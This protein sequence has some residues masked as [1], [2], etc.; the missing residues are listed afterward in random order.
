MGGK[1]TQQ[2]LMAQRRREVV[3]LDRVAA[4]VGEDRTSDL[5]FG[6]FGDDGQ[7]QRVRHRDGGTDD[8]RV[9]LVGGDVGDE[10]A[11]ELQFVGGQAVQVGERRITGPVVVDGDPH[12]E[13]GELAEHVARL[14]DVGHDLG[15]CDLERERARRKSVGPEM[16]GD[17]ADEGTIREV[18]PGDVDRQADVE[19]I[20]P[21][22]G[23][24]VTGFGEHEVG[25]LADEAH[26]LRDRDELVGWNLAVHG[27]EPARQR[28]DTDHLSGDQ[29]GDRLVHHAQLLAAGEGLRQVASE[30]ELAL[31]ALIVLGQV[32]LDARALVFRVVHRDVCPLKEGCDVVSVVGRER[33]SRRSC[34]REGD[35]IYVHRL[36]DRPEQIAHDAQG[37]FGPGDVRHDEREF[38]ASEPGNR[39]SATAR[40]DEAF[41]DLAQQPIAG[42]VAK[43]VIDFLETVEVEQGDCRP[44]RLCERVRRAI[45]E[46]DPVRQPGQQVVGRLVPLAC[47]LET[48]LLDE[49]RPL[50]GRACVSSQRLEEPQVIVVE[51]V[52]AL[53]TVERDKCSEGPFSAGERHNDGVPEFAEERVGV[54]F[55]F[56]VSGRAR[57]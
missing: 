34:D 19:A 24:L 50:Q 13:I 42:V 4:G 41:G 29:A 26:L 33:D 18:A 25:D 47:G 12:S 53:V 32:Q 55:P 20:S 49:L 28:L 52:E 1:P 3:A 36:G 6:T 56:V 45:K 15:L 10:G 21:P 39:R 43:G 37:L 14:A 9:A 31:H 40:A 48:K 57:P 5:V 35:P 54:R 23:C 51:G 27:M 38:V 16:R 30:E 44:A 46:Q 17:V 11:I 2:I 7:A 8:D 22:S